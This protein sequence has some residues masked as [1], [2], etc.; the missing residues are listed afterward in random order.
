MTAV[1]IASCLAG[2]FLCRTPSPPFRFKFMAVGTRGDVPR[3][4]VSVRSA[5]E[6]LAALAGGCDLIDLKDPTRGSLGAAEPAVIEAACAAVRSAGSAPVSAALGEL[7]EWPLERAT[8]PLDPAVTLVKLGLSHCA[9]EPAWPRRWRAVRDR[10]DGAA[11]RPLGWMA[12]LYAD[13][14][15]AGP[16]PELLLDLAA[17]SGCRGVLVDTFLKDGRRLLD[18][19]AP[20]E[21]ARWRRAAAGAG[22]TF[23]VAGSLRVADLSRIVEVAPDIVAVRGA[24]CRSEERTSEICSAAVREFGKALKAAF[25]IDA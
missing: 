11:G 17:T 13:A 2:F 18:H 25:G 15:A 10:F 5:D 23:A 1:P 7:W 22:L 4:L 14:A 8:P 24:A 6:A 20:E 16:C 3:L 21:L 9:D 19:V 12:V